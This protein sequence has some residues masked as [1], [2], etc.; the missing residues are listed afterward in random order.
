MGCSTG[1]SGLP[2]DVVL[3]HSVQL[4]H[5]RAEHEIDILVL[6]PDVGIAV[7]EV[8]GGLVTNENGR[9]FPSGEPDGRHKLQDPQAQSQGSAH[10]LK[11]WLSDQMGS[12]LTNRFVYMTAFPIRLCR[13]NGSN[14][15]ANGPS[16]WIR[17]I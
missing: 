16:S 4:R 5:G 13:W 6:W 1:R 10:A 7:I 17:K 8:K 2:D 3:A 14:Q 9:W 12:L 15:A 11:N